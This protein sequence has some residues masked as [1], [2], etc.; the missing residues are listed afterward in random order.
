MKT[1]S[2]A[3]KLVAICLAAALLPLAAVQAANIQLGIDVLEQSGFRAVAGKRVGLLTHPAGVNRN[4]VSTIEVLRRAPN[5]QLVALFGPEHG[6]YGDEK[7]NVPVDD[8]VDPRTGLPVYSL[9]GKY[10]TPTAKMLNGLDALVV[11]LQ[12][13]GVRSYTYVSCM[14]YA[15]EACF[16]AGVEVVVL[17]R[18]N[19]LGGL[20]VDGPPLDREWRSY[21]GAFHVPYVHG[22]TI[23]ELARIAKY[24]PGWMEVPDEVRKR[25]KL[26]IIPMQ[27]WRR[28]MLWP[29]T[30]LKWVPT[31]PYIP[32]LSAVLGYAMTGLGSQEGGFSHG[33]GTP[34]PFRL[35]RHKGKTPAEVKRALESCRIPGLSYRILK[36][37]SAAGAPVEGVYVSVSNWSVVRPT[38]LSFHM[39]RI[40]EAWTPGNPFA[41]AKNT[42]LF[43]KHVGSTAWW[44]EISQ[45]GSEARVN[46]F[47]ENWARN[48]QRFQ[49]EAKRFWIY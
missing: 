47:V 1:I 31:S 14:R 39:M 38:E 43:N 34:Y 18:P 22:L 41:E 15:M 10:R 33:I 21:V 20:K 23:A 12:D 36:T 11:D 24:T 16:E 4:G 6:I 28:D 2:P 29:A 13:V 9:Y 26:T 8:K 48:A 40:T 25:G 32:D 30:G 27:G 3:I 49:Q 7:A 37:R 45:R 17:D 42:N 44:D 46:L 35:L 5:V 19:P